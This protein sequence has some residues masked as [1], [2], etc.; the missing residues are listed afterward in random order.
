MP[1]FFLTQI[2][3]KLSTVGLRGIHVG[4]IRKA[5]ASVFREVESIQVNGKRQ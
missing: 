4:G 1:K 5:S 2:P 3:I